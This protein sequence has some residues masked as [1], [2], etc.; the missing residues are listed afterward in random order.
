MGE[1]R[2]PR[3]P[4]R[5]EVV[6]SLL[7]PISLRNAVEGFYGEGHSAV[8]ADERAKDRSMLRALEDEAIRDAVRPCDSG[9]RSGDMESSP[10]AGE[11]FECAAGGSLNP[12]VLNNRPGPIHDR[13]IGRA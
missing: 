8:L 13:Q 2:R 6:G 12:G 1:R 3:D 7:R 10:V 11:C 9:D 5:A 4:P